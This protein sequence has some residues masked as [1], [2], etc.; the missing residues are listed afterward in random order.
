MRNIMKK[1]IIFFDGDGTLWYP[2]STKYKEM[3]HWIYLKTQDIN[4]HYKQLVL[5]PTVLPTLNKLKKM[6]IIT[7]LLSTHP[8]PPKEASFRINHKVNHFKLN[9]LFDE[10]H[11]TREYHGSKGEFIVKILKKYKIPKSK[12]LMIGDHYRWDYR[13]AKDVG[14]DALLIESD[15]MKKDKYGKRVKNTVKKLSEVLKCI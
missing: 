8:H 10:I 15:Y 4:E 12:A 3:P 5:I 1:E 13:S 14:V 7:V 2:K 11:A 9:T 6:G